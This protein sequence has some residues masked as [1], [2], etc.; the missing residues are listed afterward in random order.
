MKSLHRHCSPGYILVQLSEN[1][2]FRILVKL[3]DDEIEAWTPSPGR[4]ARSQ[5]PLCSLVQHWGCYPL[6]IPSSLQFDFTWIGIPVDFRV[7][8]WHTVDCD[9]S[10]RPLVCLCS[11]LSFYNSF[12][13][14]HLVVVLFSFPPLRGKESSHHIM[15]RPRF[16][17]RSRSSPSFPPPD[18]HWL[19]AFLMLRQS[20]SSSL[21]FLPTRL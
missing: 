9:S 3:A 18:A 7:C 11:V 13:T 5:S 8:T 6:W 15:R 17:C 10:S 20:Q 14:V 1:F 21:S 19:K 4:F 2:R 12:L 16:E